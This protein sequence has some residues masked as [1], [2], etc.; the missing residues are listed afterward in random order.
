MTIHDIHILLVEE[1]DR[2]NTDRLQQSFASQVFDLDTLPNISPR[3]HNYPKKQ[4]TVSEINL[5][6]EHEIHIN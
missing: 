4:I 3:I 6:E 1:S 5:T 2:S